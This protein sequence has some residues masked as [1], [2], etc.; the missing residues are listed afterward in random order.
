MQT[1]L[2]IKMTAVHSSE[3]VPTLPLVSVRPP[4]AVLANGGV[5][6]RDVDL[7]LKDSGLYLV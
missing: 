2:S 1:P 6:T 5:S 4:L 7:M 3:T